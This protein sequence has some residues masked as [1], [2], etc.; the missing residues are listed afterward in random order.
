M[1]AEPGVQRVWEGARGPLH[2]RAVPGLPPRLLHAGRE[3]GS[4]ARVWDGAGPAA[5][6]TRKGLTLYGTG[7][8]MKLLVHSR[9]R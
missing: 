9:A 6:R 2:E 4:R 8:I 5:E 7:C 1:Q 3:H